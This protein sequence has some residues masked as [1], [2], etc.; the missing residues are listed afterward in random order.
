MVSLAC[1]PARECGGLGS[2]G[3][4]AVH[5]GQ[6]V[7]DLCPLGWADVLAHVHNTVRGYFWI[8]LYQAAGE[9]REGL[10]S[11]LPLRSVGPR[12]VPRIPVQGRVI[13]Q[14]G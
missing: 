12:A 4:W 7:N 9:G 8:V 6:K 3:G 13:F 11:F 14:G 5:G 2:G 1:G 10:G